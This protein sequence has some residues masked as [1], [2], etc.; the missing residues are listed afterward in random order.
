MS[1]KEAKSSSD[2]LSAKVRNAL[3][4]SK[5]A[6]PKS[7]KEPLVDVAH[8]RTAIAR[9]DQVKDVSNSE[10]DHA[11]K[12]IVAAAKMFDVEVSEGDWRDL[13]KE[14]NKAKK[15]IVKTKEGKKKTIAKKMK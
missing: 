14:G 13:V 1:P 6:F 2:T 7:R 10:R 4:D 3:P 5:F 9:F 8:V 15:K 11:W 12:R